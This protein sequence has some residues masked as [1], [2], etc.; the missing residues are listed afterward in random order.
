MR[1]YIEYYN[2]MKAV[3]PAIIITGPVAGGF[4]DSS[5]MYDGNT[6]IQDFIEFAAA[7]A[8]SIGENPNYY[9][10]AIDYHW[11]PNWG[12]PSSPYPASQA[13]TSTS[14]LDA[15]P[16]ALQSFY[17]SA[18]VT[19]GGN[20][21]VLMSE[22]NTDPGDT[23]FQ[24]Q[25]GSGLFVADALGHFITAFGPLGH[26]NLWDTVSGAQADINATEGDLGY[27]NDENDGY[28]Y[29][30]HAEY[31]A[32]KMMTNYWAIPGDSNNHN[33]IQIAQNAITI[34]GNYP[35]PLLAS[36][37]DYRPD[38][39]LSLAVINKDPATTFAGVVTLTAPFTANTTANGWTFN[40]S[41]YVW[42]TT[43]AP[44]HASP[45]NAPTTFT[46][47]GSGNAFPVTFQPY[48]ITVLQFTNASLPTNTPTTT[49]T[50]TSTPTVT[51]TPNYGP[52]TLVD[53]FDDL[54]RDGPS[55][56]SRTDLWNGPWNTSV[57]TYG[58]GITVQYGVSPGQ[59]G[60]PYAVKIFGN[61]YTNE[62]T[63]GPVTTGWSNYTAG[64]SQWPP[65]AHNLSGCGIVGLEFWFYGDGNTYRVTVESQG[66]T[67]YNFYGWEFTPPKNQWTFLQIPFS[68][69]TRQA[70]WGSQTGL[71][72]YYGGTD[73]TGVQFS[74]QNTGAFSYEIDQVGFYSASGFSPTMSPTATPTKT[75]TSTATI[76][77]TMTPTPTVTITPTVTLTPTITNTPIFSF[78]FTS[79]PSYT[80]TF[81]P[82]P[83]YTP[84]IT[85]TPT[86][87]PTFTPSP[88]VT[89]SPTTDP[90]PTA[91][92]TN[93]NIVY[94][95][96]SDGQTPLNVA[97]STSQPVDQ[98]SAKLFTLAY[99]KIYENDGL[100]PSQGAHVATLDLKD[101]GLNL[102]NGLYYLVLEWKNGK[103]ITRQIMKVLILH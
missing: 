25:L 80:P 59:A 15:F 17:A 66:V 90:T 33:L 57:D 72:T 3:D 70:G 62:P 5:N 75:V 10:N 50:I 9:I 34:K 41:N 94:P 51:S 82:T 37:S 43:T 78:T 93:F 30:P 6:V 44:Y 7:A 12:T 64:L 85:S 19:G 101:A 29:Q 77:S 96:P 92:I 73:V 18:T 22:Y 46:A 54:S 71:P 52:L 39:L 24:V 26:C 13:M 81:S 48:S 68:M 53:N 91:T 16:A 88:T 83:S 89:N 61:I 63:G 103:Q 49:P 27:L 65:V 76:T 55:P 56:P 100:D 69:M 38:G 98:V 67:D 86:A 97:Y 8:V 40:A 1:R 74:T 14:S 32:M 79:T 87:S 35:Y 11:Y 28:Q 95:N 45:D 42:E 99:R 20:I 2:A 58:S 21:P 36:Y 4:C 47:T 31:W 23:N 102:S 60:T 84:T